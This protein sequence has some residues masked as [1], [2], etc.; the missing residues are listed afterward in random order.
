[1]HFPW[2]LLGFWERKLTLFRTL[3]CGRYWAKFMSP[4]LRRRRQIENVQM[5]YPRTDS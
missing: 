2:P 1:M 4:I 3:L 5:V